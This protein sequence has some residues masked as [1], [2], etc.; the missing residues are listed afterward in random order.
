MNEKGRK[1]V[2]GVQAGT[3]DRGWS[4]LEAEILLLLLGLFLGCLSWKSLK[5]KERTRLFSKK[6]GVACLS[7]MNHGIYLFFLV[8]S[9][10]TSVLPGK[11][12]EILVILILGR[13][14]LCLA[15]SSLCLEWVW[16]L[17][18]RC[19][20]SSLN[21]QQ[22]FVKSESWRVRNWKMLGHSCY[23]DRYVLVE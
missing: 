13:N 11:S 6:Q 2:R 20:F 16:H 15:G 22:N 7:I 21:I 23:F 12:F 17:L 18:D 5:K 9:E 14:L 19:E 8:S 10:R 4:L 1:A 3:A